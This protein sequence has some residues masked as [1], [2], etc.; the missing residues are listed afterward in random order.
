MA[1]ALITYASMSG[2][3]EDIAFIIKDTLQEYEL[4]IDCVEIDDVDVSCLTFY[5]YVLIVP[6]HGGTAICPTKRRIFSKRSNS[7]SLM[8]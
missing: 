5:D 2:N 1:K 8:V 4:D 6:I 7:F 3:T